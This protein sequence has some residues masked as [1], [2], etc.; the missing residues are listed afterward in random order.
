VEGGRTWSSLVRKTNGRAAIS[1]E[2]IE[3]DKSKSISWSA[4][5][6]SGETIPYEIAAYLG[7]IFFEARTT[8]TDSK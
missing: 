3:D 6:G 4:L 2:G 7:C 8:S 5:V 1:G